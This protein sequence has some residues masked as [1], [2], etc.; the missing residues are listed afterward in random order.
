LTSNEDIGT[1]LDF[2]HKLYNQVKCNFFIMAYRGYCKSEGN[3]SEAGIK[4]DA[5]AAMEYIFSRD[6]VIDTKNVFVMGRS[7]GGAVA[8]YVLA[9]GEYKV[10]GKTG[11]K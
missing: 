2:I 9:T 5:H 7:L 10:K 6:D 11:L 4:M 8:T 1:R 3:P